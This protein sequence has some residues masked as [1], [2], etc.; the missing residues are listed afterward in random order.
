MAST[1][2]NAAAASMG[3]AYDNAYQAYQRQQSDEIQRSMWQQQQQAAQEHQ[4]AQNR[5]L[6]QQT[7]WD[8]QRADAAATQF[9][10]ARQAAQKL[11]YGDQFGAYQGK[12][13]ASLM[14]PKTGSENRYDPVQDT[15][16]L[17]VDQ[18]SQALKTIQD[19][20]KLL[21]PITD[22]KAKDQIALLRRQATT[23]N[24]NVFAARR[25]LLDYTTQK[26]TA[27]GQGYA[28]PPGQHIAP[29]VGEGNDITG[30]SD[31]PTARQVAP[32]LRMPAGPPSAGYG[33]PAQAPA[34]GVPAT[35]PAMGNFGGMPATMPAGQPVAAPPRNSM[36][37]AL[38]YSQP[39][40]FTKRG[41]ADNDQSV[42]I[43]WDTQ[44]Q[45]WVYVKQGR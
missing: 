36:D 20:I 25:K 15:L 26:A 29:T 32:Q 31:V 9:G 11:G 37:A 1:F 8:K 7:A 14:T 24:N 2:W 39:Q 34:Y 41:Y 21:D 43:A 17:E 30:G 28:V 40:R 3:S 27:L 35:Q 44:T 13:P 10:A 5:R 6:D 18:H 33:M 12:L 45:Q 19:Q 23:I 16:K 42:E 22:P 38:V 4:D